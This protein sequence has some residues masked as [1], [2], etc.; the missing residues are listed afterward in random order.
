[1]T[2]KL[3]AKKPLKLAAIAATVCVLAPTAWS[4]GI[5]VR[6]LEDLMTPTPQKIERGKKIYADNCAAC[7]GANGAGDGAQAAYFSAG[8]PNLAAAEYRYGGGPLQVNN[9]IAKGTNGHPLFEHLP[10]PDLWAVTHFV[11]SLGPTQNL[12]DPADVVKQAKFEAREGICN[13]AVKS[14]I[15]EKMQ[16]KGDSQVA[17]GEAVYASNCASCHGE[18]GKGA[19]SAAG[20]L[21]PPPRNF[22]AGDG[23]TNGTS[24]LAIFNTLANGIEGTSMAGFKHLPEADRWALTHMIR[25][26][27]VPAAARA[28]ATPEQVDAVCRSLSGGAS[29]ATISIDDAMRIVV[30]DV[31]EVR[32]VRMTQYGTAWVVDGANTTRGQALYEQHCQDCHGPRGAGRD[33]G[34]YGTQPPYLFVKVNAL[35]PGLAGGTYKDFAG[36]SIA[37]A[38]IAIPDVTGASH[39]AED[40]WKALHAY[41]ASL[42]GRGDVKPVSA[43][44]VPEPAESVEGGATPDGTTD[45]ATEDGSPTA[46]PTEESKPAPKPATEAKPQPAAEDAAP[47]EQPAAAPQE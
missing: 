13:P 39:I 45:G 19:G 10:H 40:D 26:K 15:D 12:T 8:V 17:A 44:P 2:M 3:S 34:P 32:L 1:M 22:T 36:R 24:S 33:L 27:W 31:D 5:G 16:F 4:Q 18:D 21:N 11:R 35:E 7:H 30:E 9:T 41:V 6:N 43:M 47:K 38:H 20:A 46:A 14:G 42:E 23:W 37:G 29:L 28:D 25:Q